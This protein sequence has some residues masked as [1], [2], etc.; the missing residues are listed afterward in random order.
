MQPGFFLLQRKDG[1][2]SSEKPLDIGDTDKKAIN[3]LRNLVMHNRDLTG[4]SSAMPHNYEK[5]RDDF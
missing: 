5:F 4:I 3:D 1:T 2:T